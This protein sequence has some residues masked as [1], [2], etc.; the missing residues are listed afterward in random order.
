MTTEQMQNLK[1]QLDALAATIQQKANDIESKR[2]DEIAIDDEMQTIKMSEMSGVMSARF[3]INQKLMFTND[4]QRKAALQ[5]ALDANQDYQS[6]KSARS[7]KIVERVLLESEVEFQRKTYRS[8]ELQ[9]LFHA[10]A[11]TA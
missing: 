11:P 5:T 10:N 7:V 9:M 1:N 2:Q 3:E 4:D 6:L 8:L